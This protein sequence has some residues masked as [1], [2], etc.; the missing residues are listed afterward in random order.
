MW[1]VS[2]GA[3][4]CVAVFLH[5]ASCCLCFHPL[6]EESGIK[7]ILVLYRSYISKPYLAGTV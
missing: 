5:L 1:P 3:S 4:T 7:G 2:E 6:L